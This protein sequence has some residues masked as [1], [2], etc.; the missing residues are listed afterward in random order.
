VGSV[1][2]G[3]FIGGIKSNRL[4]EVGDGSIIISFRMIS[5]TPVSDSCRIFRS[6]PYRFVGICDG[7][8]GIALPTILAATVV[9]CDGK[10]M[11]V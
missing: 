6:K 2:E 10:I 8:I 5:N 11:D 9:V 4:S 3:I 1:E 7:V